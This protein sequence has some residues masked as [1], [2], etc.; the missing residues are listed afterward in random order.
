MT[1]QAAAA[2]G[3][4]SMAA[5]KGRPVPA[6]C[7]GLE[8]DL[9]DYV[10][11]TMSAPNRETVAEHVSQ[12]RSCT[13]ALRRLEAGRRAFDR[14]PNASLPPRIAEELVRA[15]IFAA[16]V[17]AHGGNARA[18]LDE[19]LR[20]L[21]GKRA[22]APSGAPPSRHHANAPQPSRP[23]RPRTPLP[24]VW[25]VDPPRPRSATPEMP[26]NAR[27]TPVHPSQ[28]A[29]TGT[30]FA[31]RAGTLAATRPHN[32]AA[33]P[34]ATSGH[35]P[36]PK[37]R[38]RARTRRL[39]PTVVTVLTLFAAAAGVGALA[40]LTLSSPSDLTVAPM[41][42]SPVDLGGDRV[43]PPDDEASTQSDQAGPET[44]SAPNRVDRREPTAGPSRSRTPTA[45]LPP[46]SGSTRGTSTE[47]TTDAP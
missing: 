32:D 43:I 4:N 7:V 24:P 46:G 8:V 35:H 17:R 39:R 3:V 36:K 13:A 31:K 2:R 5:R 23:S 26:Q 22:L 12:C 41:S 1:C 37:P 44:S 28:G 19:A 21:A 14:P 33:R 40:A 30:P 47:A 11:D 42:N 6:G 9:A 16:P 29:H 25:T 15:L 27:R 20:L 10:E 34:R 38:S 18:V 45:Q